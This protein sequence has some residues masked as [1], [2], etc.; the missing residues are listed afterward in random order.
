LKLKRYTL[1]FTRNAFF[2]RFDLKVD[3]MI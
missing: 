2:L 1:E 3:D